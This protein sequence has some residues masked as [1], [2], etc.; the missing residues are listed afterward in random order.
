MSASATTY[1][2]ARVQLQHKLDLLQEGLATKPND[3]SN[4]FN[5]KGKQQKNMA[6]YEK[7]WLNF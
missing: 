4:C 3:L 1:A 6:L 2:S 5:Q 7:D